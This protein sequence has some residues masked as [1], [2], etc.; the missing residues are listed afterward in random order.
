ME[1]IFQTLQVNQE[2]ARVYLSLLKFGAKPAGAL[3]KITNIKRPTLYV[4]L[5][6]LSRVGLVSQSLDAGVKI[7]IP[8]PSEKIRQ[9]FNKKIS[10]LEKQK[11]SV[12][13]FIQK[14][15]IEDNTGYLQPRMQFFEGKSGIEAALEDHLS[16]SNCKIRAFWSIKAALEVTSPDFSII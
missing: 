15:E 13:E 6:R 8:Q 9:I 12:E 10:D 14:I 5:E 3:A 1:K 16:Y 4:Y 7:F 11:N 2:E